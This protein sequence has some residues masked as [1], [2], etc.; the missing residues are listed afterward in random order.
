M[1]ACRISKGLSCAGYK[2]VTRLVA[3]GAECACC[4]ARG[5]QQTDT[6]HTSWASQDAVFVFELALHIQQRLRS[7]YKTPETAPNEN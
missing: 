5:I 3:Q 2:L 4:T 1:G 6:K 7:P